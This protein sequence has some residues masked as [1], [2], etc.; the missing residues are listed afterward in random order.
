MP[1]NTA[2]QVRKNSARVSAEADLFHALRN[3]NAT[4]AEVKAAK[5][6][7]DHM[8]GGRRPGYRKAINVAIDEMLEARPEFTAEVVLPQ[9]VP[10][11]KP[12]FGKK[13]D[14]APVV[15]E[16]PVE[17]VKAKPAKAEKAPARKV[18]TVKNTPGA[19]VRQRRLTRRTRTVVAIFDLSHTEG[20]T[21]RPDLTEAV[22]ANPQ[23]VNG[24]KYAVACEDHNSVIGVKNYEAAWRAGLDATTFCA[25]CATAAQ[26]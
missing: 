22:L 5:A 11:E 7:F 2:A 17:E 21:E 18:E 3:E 10:A 1:N 23:S 20:M 14:E 15:E 9:V 24:A 19:F 26:D 16:A 25:T 13:V 12:D 6:V 8:T 4:P